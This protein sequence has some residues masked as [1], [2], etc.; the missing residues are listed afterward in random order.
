ML[1]DYRWPGN[2]RE[3][4]QTLTRGVAL[5]A[6]LITPEHLFHAPI[7]R[8]TPA[9]PPQ[10]PVV[11]RFATGTEP[12][13]APPPPPSP[14]PPRIQRYDHVMR[15]VISDALEQ[16]KSLRAA[17]VALGLPKSTLAD[18]ARRMGIPIPVRRP[19]RR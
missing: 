5:S 4:R 9:E 14:V 17:A 1:R 19:D 2:V 13:P 7:R 11:S 10:I 18:K 3:L 8:T 12:P 15:D 16:H 6:E